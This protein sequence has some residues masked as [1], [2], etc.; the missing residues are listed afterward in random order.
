MRRE[1]AGWGPR[2]HYTT[3]FK[4]IDGVFSAKQQLS[5]SPVGLCSKNEVMKFDYKGRRKQS[6]AGYTVGRCGFQAKFG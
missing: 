5:Q 3:A 4:Y 2:S 6:Q 1:S